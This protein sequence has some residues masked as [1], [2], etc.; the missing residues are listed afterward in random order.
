MYYFVFL[1]LFYDVNSAH[2]TDRLD[3]ALVRCCAALSQCS[4]SATMCTVHTAHL[5]YTVEIGI[6]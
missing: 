3:T 1:L 5:F 2:A 6:H 4:R